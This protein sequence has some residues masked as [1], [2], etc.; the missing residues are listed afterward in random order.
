M[1]SSIFELVPTWRVWW[2]IHRYPKP[3]QLEMWAHFLHLTPATRHSPWTNNLWMWVLLN[4]IV[5]AGLLAVFPARRLST[6][7]ILWINLL[8]FALFNTLR[9][10]HFALKLTTSLS[11]LYEQGDAPLLGLLPA[12]DLTRALDIVRTHRYPL[13]STVGGV[14]SLPLGLLLMILWFVLVSA[15]EN[16]YVVDFSGIF[17]VAGLWLMLTGLLRYV[18]YVQSFM[19]AL[20]LALLITPERERAAAQARVFVGFVFLQLALY[21][22]LSPLL[23]ALPQLLQ[24]EAAFRLQYDTPYFWWIILFTPLCFVLCRELINL[25]LWRQ[26]RRS[27]GA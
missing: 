16:T 5:I 14:I 25:V 27:L 17:A 22:G 3:K 4:F 15:S 21:L 24:P 10:L 6:E 26:V 8:C 1:D 7:I 12:D 23:F 11:R 2:L 20:L 9:S 13:P 19:T 18:D